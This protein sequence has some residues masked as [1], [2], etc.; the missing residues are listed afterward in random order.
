MSQASGRASLSG[1]GPPSDNEEAC[2]GATLLLRNA[3]LRAS[4]REPD[5][6]D[7]SGGT[8]VARDVGGWIARSDVR[9]DDVSDV[10]GQGLDVVGRECPDGG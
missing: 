10:E 5:W 8:L 1:A 6:R 4:W 9:G 2:P 3:G 7:A